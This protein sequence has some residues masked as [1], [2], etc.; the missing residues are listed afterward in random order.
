MA[1]F[2]TIYEEDSEESDVYPVEMSINTL[3]D[4]IIIRGTGYVTVF[5]LSNKFDDEFPQQLFA[6]VA[7]EEYKE[8]IDRIN[9]VLMKT[10]PMNIKWLL[11]GCICCCCTLGC[12]LWPVVCLS[13]RSRHSIEKAVDWENSRLY[14]KLGLHWA[15]C[16]EK[17]ENSNM[18]EYVL[19]IEYVPKESI[20]KPD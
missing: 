9:S 10:L 8:S 14:H 5:G 2:D 18:M 12:S 4:P 6:K 20:L 1:E 3:P 7:P 17:C 13:K 16:K 19:K 15:L 11:C